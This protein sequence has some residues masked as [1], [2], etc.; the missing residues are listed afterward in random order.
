MNTHA[1]T[2]PSALPAVV[3]AVTANC[4]ICGANNRLAA[5]RL[6]EVARC[7]Q[8]R[9]PMTP[10]Q[11]TVAVESIEEFEALV[12]FATVPVIMEF[13]AAWCGPCRYLA[14]ELERL[15]WSLPGRAIVATVDTDRLPEAALAHGVNSL[16][17]IVLF[18]D[19]AEQNR[20]VGAM[21]AESIS[22]RLGVA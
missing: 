11:S 18:Q 15:A 16:P 3:P 5:H 9:V 8:C 19:G 6:H 1:A 13:G 10:L 17:T 14:P 7:G 12:H 21:T 22:R 4:R 20:V 2:T